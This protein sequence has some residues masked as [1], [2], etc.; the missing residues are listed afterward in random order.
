MVNDLL[1]IKLKMPSFFDRERF[2]SYQ[3]I[4]NTEGEVK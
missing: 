3:Y 1:T 2:V 4:S